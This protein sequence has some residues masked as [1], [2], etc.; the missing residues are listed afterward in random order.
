MDDA[1]G[2]ADYNHDL[3]VKTITQLFIVYMYSFIVL[4][5]LQYI[6]QTVM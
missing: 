2:K 5:V 3:E 6:M 4:L 1:T